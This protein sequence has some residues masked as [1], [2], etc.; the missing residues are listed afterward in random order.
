[1]AS[2]GLTLHIYVYMF[3]QTGARRGHTESEHDHLYSQLGSG[4]YTDSQGS[5]YYSM[6]DY[7]DILRHAARH[8]IDVI[9]ELDF[10]AHSRAAVRSMEERHALFKYKN[11]LVRANAFLISDLMDNSSYISFQHYT[12]NV[13]N[14]CIN[15]TYR[16]INYV[17]TKIKELHKDIL[18]LKVLHIGG[19]E[20]PRGALLMSQSCMAIYKTKQK[21]FHHQK[22]AIIK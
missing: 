20:L 12:D 1:M 22:D 7:R 6:E 17:I 2:I 15:S 14:P 13:M 16:F 11:D 9:P 4:P 19:D 3:L 8:H 21:L 10:P 18:P 5:G